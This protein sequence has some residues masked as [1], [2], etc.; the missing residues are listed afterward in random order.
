MIR[1]ETRINI[2]GTVAFTCKITM[3]STDPSE[4]KSV[5]FCLLYFLD[6]P[7][8]ATE[9]FFSKE[10]VTQ[11]KIDDL[12]RYIYLRIFRSENPTAEQKLRPR[13]R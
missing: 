12:I 7:Q 11:L 1:K 13:L 3:L 6:N 10:R 9:I 8:Y 5:L 2:H 4:Y